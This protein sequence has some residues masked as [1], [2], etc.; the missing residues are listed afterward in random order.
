MRGGYFLAS[1]RAVSCARLRANERAQCGKR[2]ARVRDD[3]Q[4][5]RLEVT[6]VLG[7]LALPQLRQPDID[8]RR[9]GRNTRALRAVGAVPIELAERAVEVTDI[10]SDDE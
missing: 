2:E 3:R 4:R 7:P 5:H 9:P 1:R 8:D 10:E 6:E